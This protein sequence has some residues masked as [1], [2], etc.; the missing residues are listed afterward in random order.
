MI[1][2]DSDFLIDFLRGKG[3]GARRV[4]IELRTGSLATTAISA[5][6]LLSGART[7]A[8]AKAVET[9]LA[10]MTILPFGAE[11]GRIAAGIRL[12]VEARGLPIGM[13]DYLIAATC[14]ATDAVLLTRNRK[15]FE[16]VPGL[17]LGFRA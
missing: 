17:R 9:L 5:F 6:E 15:H 11:E 4:E 8:Q 12:E 3:E 13:A 16:R 7:P 10:A 2:A 1:V 14:I